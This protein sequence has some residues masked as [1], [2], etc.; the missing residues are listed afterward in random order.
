MLV[1]VTIYYTPIQ[2]RIDVKK[3]FFLLVCRLKSP[4]LISL[5]K[6]LRKCEGVQ[7][8]ALKKTV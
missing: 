1:L 4:T 6:L 8:F 3:K 2:S 5:L 7:K